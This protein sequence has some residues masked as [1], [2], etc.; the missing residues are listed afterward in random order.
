[1]SS[2]LFADLQQPYYIVCPPYRHTSG[3]VR[4]LNLFCHALNLLGE[5]AYLLSEHAAPKLRAPL[6]TPEI[7]AHHQRQGRKPLMLYPE[8]IDGNPFGAPLVIRYLLNVP[9]FHTGHYSYGPDDILVTHSNDILP[10]GWQALLL[11]VPTSDRSIFNNENNPYDQQRSGACFY[12]KKY[13]ESGLPLLPVTDG[14]IELSPRVAQRSLEELAELLRR[15]EV[16]YAYEHSTLC[17]EA[18]LCGCP[19]VYLPNEFMPQM[20]YNFVGRD[21]VAWGNTAEELAYA[22]STLARVPEA[23]DRVE[24]EFWEYLRQFVQHTQKAVLERPMGADSWTSF[25]DQLRIQMQRRKK[26][27]YKRAFKSLRLKVKACFGRGAR[28][29]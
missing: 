11:P 22:R 2:R 7:A 4:V 3:G 16:L 10:Q 26:P 19:V 20:Y 24:A 29:P 5:E 13:F 27:W 28:S 9:G 23:F 12:A 25:Y 8:I 1:M 21:G 14:A 15:T 18:L 6:L 17:F